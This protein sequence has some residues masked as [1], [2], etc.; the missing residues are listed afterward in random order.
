MSFD[1]YEVSNSRGRPIALYEIR[2]GN[3]VWK[4]TSADSVQYYPDDSDEGN[5]F[6]PV[7]IRDDG[8]TQGGSSEND[9]TVH[10]QGDLPVVLL[11]ADSPPTMP[12]WLTVRRKHADDPDHEAPVYWV[13]RIANVQRLDNMAEADI[14]GISISK[15]LKTGGLRLTWG[16]NCPHCVYDSACRADPADHRYARVVQAVQGPFLTIT[17][18]TD[19][20]EGSFTG[21]FVEWDRDGKGTMERRGIEAALST[22]KVKVLGRLPG[23]MAGAAVNLYPGCDQTVSTC[24]DGFDNIDNNGGF[25]FMPEKSPFDGSQVFD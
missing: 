8:M 2:W 15:L 17:V 21:G 5:R 20:A 4:Y 10:T 14:R 25:F 9:F 23:L 6:L 22:T 3:T 1:T 12:V 16:K 11:Y 7:A 18:E 24:N 19:P 13:G